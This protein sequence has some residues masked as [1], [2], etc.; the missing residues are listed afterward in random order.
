MPEYLN[1][2]SIRNAAD[3]VNATLLSKGYAS[4][5]LLFPTINWP[6]IVADQP[7][8]DSLVLETHE[9]IY[10]NDKNVINLI[11]SLCQAIDKTSS[12]N[13]TFNK[14]LA[15]TEK[16]LQESERKLAMSEARNG[17]LEQK[18][19]KTATF[20]TKSLKEQIGVLEKAQKAHIHDIQRL[21]AL[22]SDLEA[23]YDVEMRKKALEISSLKDKLLDSRNLSNTL[24]YGN[25]SLKR[26]PVQETNSNV[27]FNNKAIVDTSHGPEKPQGLEAF[28]TREYEEIAAQLSDLIENLMKE[29]SR[30]SKFVKEANTYLHNVNLKILP[31][32]IKGGESATIPSPSDYID[33]N[34]SIDANSE[35]EPFEEVSRPLLSSIYNHYHNVQSLLEALVPRK[36]AEN[37]SRKTVQQLVQENKVLQENWKEAMKALD[38]WKT[39]NRGTDRKRHRSQS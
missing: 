31:L 34:G 11:Y 38:D 23:K 2:E 14:T 18:I 32:S 19:D 36:S 3:L 16:A 7:H 1:V 27:I 24:T 35:I 39:Y 26:H 10:N 37:D 5:K 15:H 8:K 33:V 21:R 30:Y 17:A 20:E 12:Q 22:N 29:N 25:P 9:L 28:V 6:E 13:K 4:E